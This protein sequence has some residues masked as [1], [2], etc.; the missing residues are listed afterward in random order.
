MTTAPTLH[1]GRLTLRAHTM[2]DFPAYRD[3]WASDHLR[4]MGGPLDEKQSWACFCKYVAQW[5]L[6]GH[7]AWAVETSD[8]SAF[9]GQVGLNAH[10]NFPELELGWLVL[11]AAQ[12]Q[13]IA[14]QAAV[15]ARDWAFATLRARSLVSYIHQD[16]ARSISLA[17]RLGASLDQSAPACPYKLHAVYRHPTPQARP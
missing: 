6:L 14:Y 11:P 5:P 4:Y 17:E 8:S 1:T 9:V 2:A 12:G 13:G 16:N 3:V 15:A 10:P 7:G